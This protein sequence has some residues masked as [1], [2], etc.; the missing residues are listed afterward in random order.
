[1]M[2]SMES[3]RDRPARHRTSVHRLE[4]DLGASEMNEEKFYNVELPEEHEIESTQPPGLTYS[5]NKVYASIGF[6]IILIVGLFT[7]ASLPTSGGNKEER[8]PFTVVDDAKNQDSIG[9]GYVSVQDSTIPPGEHLRATLAPTIRMTVA[10]SSAPITKAPVFKEEETELPSVSPATP[11]PDQKLP[12]TFA[13]STETATSSP[14]TYQPTQPMHLKEGCLFE[15]LD[16]ENRVAHNRLY[17]GQYICNGKGRY[18]F[19]VDV[20]GNVIYRDLEEPDSLKWLFQNPYQKKA[21]TNLSPDQIRDTFY[22]Q[23]KQNGEL[24]LHWVN[25]NEEGTDNTIIWA[26]LPKEYMTPTENCTPNHD[27]PYLEMHDNGVMIVNWVPLNK[28]T[29]GK[30]EGRFMDLYV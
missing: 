23:L 7:I 25:K 10:P 21:V 26:T 24:V 29:H 19:G 1:M 16:N 3:E 27:C 13:P 20:N 11:A 22:L 18:R 2:E 28:K 9:N 8:A 17:A 15:A 12:A 6:V 30:I 14:T 5:R 4:E